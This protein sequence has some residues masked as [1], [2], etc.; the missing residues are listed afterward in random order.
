MKN[1]K[2]I[3]LRLKDPALTVVNR[4]V[5]QLNNFG[6]EVQ[7]TQGFIVKYAVE[8][9]AANLDRKDIEFSLP[10]FY[11]NQDVLREYTDKEYLEMHPY[12]NEDDLKFGYSLDE[13]ELISKSLETITNI[14]SQKPHLEKQY[15]TWKNISNVINN[16]YHLLKFSIKEEQERQEWEE[17][18]LS[19]QDYQ[20]IEETIKKGKEKIE[21][22]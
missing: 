2:Q 3:G 13:L 19:Y 12:V 9:Y 17:N 8:E 14:L 16:D 10:L 5:E 22:E 1:E 4:R 11:P 18:N 6:P 7:V 21:K 20:D 15:K